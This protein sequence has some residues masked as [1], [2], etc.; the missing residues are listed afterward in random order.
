[1]AVVFPA[2]V[3]FAKYDRL[4]HV[5]FARGLEAGSDSSGEKDPDSARSLASVG[6]G[7]ELL[8]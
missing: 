3:N 4:E 5:G 2:T 7:R 8:V 1:M 6:S